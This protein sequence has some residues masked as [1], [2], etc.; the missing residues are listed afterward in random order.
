MIDAGNASG[1]ICNGTYIYIREYGVGNGTWQVL[2]NGKH[3]PANPFNYTDKTIFRRKVQCGIEITYSNELVINYQSPFTE[4]DYNYVRINDILIPGIT[5]WEQADN[6][7]T[8]SKIQSTTYLDG[9][10]RPTQKV[11]KQGSLKQATP[12]LD[13]NN[14]NNYQDIVTHIEYDSL[15]RAPKSFLPYATTTNL[16]LFKTNAATEQKSFINTKYGEPVNN[17][18]TYSTTTFDGSPLNRIINV[19]LPGSKWNTN[20]AYKGITNDY[21]IN[22]A[23]EK[24]RIWNIGY[25]TGSVPVS[26]VNDIYADGKLFKNITRDEKDKLIIEYT[27]LS[28][29]TILKKVQEKEGIDIDMNG[30]KGWLCTYFVYDD[31]NRL[32]YTITPKAV[33]Q[34]NLANSWII[35]DA[36]KKGLCF[37]QEYD[38][39]GRVTIKHSPDGGEVWMVYDN[40]DRL[41]LSQDENQRNR[42]SQ[43]PSKPNQWSFSL[44]DENDRA[45]VTGLINDTRNRVALQTMADQLSANPQNKQVEVYTGAWETITAYNPVAGKVTASNTFY[46]GTCTNSVTNTVSYYDEYVASSK[47]Y[48]TIT[49]NDFAPTT[50][51]YV[52]TPAKSIRIKGNVTTSKVR[53]LND[54][55]DNDIVTD[56]SFLNTTV[57]YDEDG[58]TIQTQSDNIK[59]A[60]DFTAM[61]YDF[62]GK[63]LSTRIKHGATGSV[64]NN[65]LTVTKNEYDIL[66]RPVQLKKLFTL[67]NAD[68]TTL[69]K[70]K[71]L[72]EAALDELGRVRTK[73]V[74]ADPADANKPL[75]TMDYAYNIQGWLT[76]IN[77]DYA[78]AN[79]DPGNPMTPQFSRRFG[80]YLGYENGD[81]SFTAPQWNG[82]ITGVIWRSQGDNTARKYNYTYDNINRFTGAT[83]LQK[84]TL[85][86]AWLATKVDLSSSVTSYDENGNIKGLKA[87]RNQARHCR[88]SFNR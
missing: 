67:A 62:A 70:Y 5:S 28:G 22:K 55:Y 3:F 77:K 58:R 11:I 29:N 37:Y 86:A 12:P 4:P 7:P 80:M 10:G 61:Q 81:N 24:V 46:C 2:G 16:G 68:V 56:D 15:G 31:F 40:R 60:T 54:K 1:G 26:G 49:N 75:E 17:V 78:L 50:N 52:Q 59:T 48:V 20:P 21:D 84:E 69:A 66:G 32:R 64:F 43:V 23:I 51:P 13:P 33:A 63:V 47:A 27:D 36:I 14:I 25:T 79:A 35:T 71:K 53:V 41:V 76:G 19:K 74:G 83:F 39:K 8:G 87:Y 44:Y 42:V 72:S 85:N 38:K 82:S 9:F 30:H 65:M 34:M 6:L 45:L 88:R 18:Y 73:K 57:Y